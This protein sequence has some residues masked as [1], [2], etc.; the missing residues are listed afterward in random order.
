MF[1]RI[2]KYFIFILL[3]I[4]I[5]GIIPLGL[6]CL[7]ISEIPA[8]ILAVL[9]IAALWAVKIIWNKKSPAKH[10]SLFWAGNIV[11]A[12]LDAAILFLIVLCTM[13]NPFWNSQSF[14]NYWGEPDSGNT[15]LTKEEALEDY[16]FAMK[17]LER[18]HP[19]AVDGLSSEIITQAEEVK[20]HIGSMERIRGYELS[21]ELESILAR[22][23]DGH[24][25][26]R[27]RFAEPLF[28]KHQY[29]HE[30]KKETL[31]GIN[32]TTLKDILHQNP[33][34]FSYE[35]ESWAVE[36][37]RKH[38][39]TLDGLQYL[40]IDTTKEITYNYVT[41]DGAQDNETVTEKDFLRKE[42]Y[43]KYEESVTG[44]DLHK[45][46]TEN[47]H[48][49]SYEIDTTRSL[50]ILKLD[51]CNLNSVYKK[52]LAEMFEKVHEL[53]IQNVAVDL[54]GNGGGDTNVAVEFID[55]LNVESYKTPSL[56]VR[57]EFKLFRSLLNSVIHYF[58][59]GE[60]AG[61]S[62]KKK[63][64]AFAGNVYVLSSSKTFS[65]AMDFTVIIQ[66]NKIGK[67]IGEPPGN[68]PTST[69]DVAC[70]TLPNS[71]LSMHV[72]SSTFHRVDITKNDLPLIPDI[73]CDAR[74][75]PD[76]LKTLIDARNSG[77]RQ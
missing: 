40:G 14:V 72:P 48:F 76:Q 33:Y 74:D 59:S 68:M 51:A 37:I 10:K 9:W 22:L 73:E 58:I 32:G 67:V 27:Y 64:H 39:F 60:S 3:H 42:A 5:L 6:F 50:A 44:D 66:D 75:A 71:G 25:S 31:V 17:Y 46:A 70:F 19:L 12:A 45:E 56:E 52:T 41:A 20:K 57:K 36:Q 61:D 21:R 55:Y 43:L 18:V 11:I 49:V 62:G 30:K 34:L 8:I 26:V 53:D 23:H 35:M 24:A 1:T 13:Y 29:E 54:R 69:G 38:A 7:S 63:G 77:D 4:L 2:L 65:A 28:M 16:E 15:T 47:N